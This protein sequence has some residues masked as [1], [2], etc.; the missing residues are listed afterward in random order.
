MPLLPPPKACR[1]RKI[2]QHLKK[3]RGRVKNRNTYNR[4]QLTKNID[5]AEPQIVG[6]KRERAKL[7]IVTAAVVGSALSHGVA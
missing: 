1:R 7:T 4:D 5:K 6:W 2:Y 3:E